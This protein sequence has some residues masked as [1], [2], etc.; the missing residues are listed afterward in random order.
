MKIANKL[1]TRILLAMTLAL[2]LV[3]A[4]WTAQAA[5]KMFASAA[6]AKRM[7]QS[8]SKERRKTSS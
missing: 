2:G 3:L 1:I 7:A 5:E 4:V 8:S 6:T